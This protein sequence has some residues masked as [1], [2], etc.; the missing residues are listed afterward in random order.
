MQ[1]SEK[2][3]SRRDKRRAWRR[4]KES[5]DEEEWCSFA[6]VLLR[7]EAMRHMLILRVSRRGKSYAQEQRRYMLI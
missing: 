1:E 2:R 6:R 5:Y 4:E 3:K 7:R